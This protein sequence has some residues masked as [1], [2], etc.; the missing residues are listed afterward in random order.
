[1]LKLAAA[2]EKNKT[3]EAE[4]SPAKIEKGE[5]RK[6][7]IA[8]SVQHEY[9]SDW[10]F[11]PWVRVHRKNKRTLVFNFFI[12]ADQCLRAAVEEISLLKL[13]LQEAQGQWVP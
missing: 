5:K 10:S 8:K 4:L 11:K 13:V 7:G 1:M 2:A 6:L 12:V 3:L 9:A